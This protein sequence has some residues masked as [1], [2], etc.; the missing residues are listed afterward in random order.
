M[1]PPPLLGASTR[2][3]VVRFRVP[4]PTRWGENLVV[5]G[6]HEFLGE[7]EPK[8]GAWM[9]CSHEGDLLVWQARSPLR[10]SGMR[11]RGAAAVR[12]R[13]PGRRSP[14]WSWPAAATF[15]GRRGR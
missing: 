9:S 5:S 14:A 4:F 7:W 1:P 12:P 6:D 10:A 8:R 13:P 11:G 2:R 15:L 3:T